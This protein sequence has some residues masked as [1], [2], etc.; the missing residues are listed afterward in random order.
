MDVITLV[1]DES[2]SINKTKLLDIHN[3][4]KNVI[5]QDDLGMN[6]G[7]YIVRVYDFMKNL[8]PS[9]SKR[10]ILDVFQQDVMVKLNLP[11][12]MNYISIAREYIRITIQQKQT[13]TCPDC[14]KPMLSEKIDGE[15]HCEECGLIYDTR[16]PGIKDVESVNTS[17]SYYSLKMNLLKAIHKFE[18]KQTTIN[19]IDLDLI[20]QEIK[21]RRLNSQNIKCEHILKILKDLKLAKYYDEVY[22]L[23]PLLT[24]RPKRS[25]QPF[26]PQILKYHDELEY[27]YSSVKNPTRINSL[28]VY[29]KLY[30]L[31]KLC[32]KNF[33]ISDLCTLKTEQKFEEHEE[34]WKEICQI[35]GWTV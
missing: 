23:L 1:I 13:I 19:K 4:I 28:N 16:L 30:K 15:M 31:L 10:N 18:G 25:I 3:K 8:N 32:D 14:D 20:S 9:C 24:S 17:R 26:V 5:V 22:S 29:F 35:T 6:Y 33:D 21:R 12:L 2:G 11:L 7:F 34:K 27:A